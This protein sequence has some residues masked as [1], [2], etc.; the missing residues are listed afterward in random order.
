MSTMTTALYR[1]YSVDGRLLYVGI[2][3]HI[4]RRWG[5]HQADKEWWTEVATA[6]VE[7]FETGALAKSAETLAI[8][9]EKPLYNKQVDYAAVLRAVDPTTKRCGRGHPLDEYNLYV[10]PNGTKTCRA[11]TRD[12][13][14][15]SVEKAMN[16]QLQQSKLDNEAS[17]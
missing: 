6:T 8:L 9:N 3:S 15:R 13:V 11:C 2:S 17:G 14:R 5:E 16:R 10:A 12:S 7:H 1:L 4:G